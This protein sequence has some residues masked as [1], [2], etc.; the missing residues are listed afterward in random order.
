[1]YPSSSLPP[2]LRFVLPP[3]LP[4]FPNPFFLFP[5][6][7]RPVSPL[8][9]FPHLSLFSLISF[10]TVTHYVR[11]PNITRIMVHISRK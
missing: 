2:F 4:G 5:T 10:V 7:L 1:M 3:S 8:G 6:S 11:S 9:A